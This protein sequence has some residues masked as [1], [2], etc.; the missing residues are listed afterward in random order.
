MYI[1]AESIK[2][3]VILG[4]TIVVAVFLSIAL[5]QLFG[6]L[7][8]LNGILDVNKENLRKTIEALPETINK[9]NG[10]I[11]D[12]KQITEKAGTVV[13]NVESAV[14]GVIATAKGTSNS[15]LEITKT[16]GEVAG[17]ILGFFGRKNR[18]RSK[19]ED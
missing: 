18:D 15:V 10:T 14:T 19:E 6:L 2:D 7:K 17:G 13:E 3:L 1:T 11:A 16:I 4:A 8:R 12:V 5:F 9:I